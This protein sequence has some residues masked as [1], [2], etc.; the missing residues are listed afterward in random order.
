M[1]NDGNDQSKQAFLE[2]FRQSFADESREHL[3]SME[4]FLVA[5]SDA[6][7]EDLDAVFRAVHSFKGNCGVFGFNVS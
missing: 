3:D 6:T 4:N 7:K 2:Q 1:S 5:S